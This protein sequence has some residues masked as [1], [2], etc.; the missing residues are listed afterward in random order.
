MFEVTPHKAIIKE[1]HKIVSN[2]IAIFNDGDYDVMYYGTNG[3][4]NRILGIIM[5]DDD[6][7]RFL[8]YIHVLLTDYQLNKYLNGEI[9][10]RSILEENQSF[11]LVD[12]KYNGVELA[13]NLVAFDE[14]PNDFL[15]LPN[16]YCPKFV[17]N[18]TFDYAVSLKGNLADLHLTAPDDLNNVN[19]HFSSFIKSA[20]GFVSDLDLT[21]SVY[22]EAL[23]AG[24]FRINFKLELVHLN[25]LSLFN[26][27]LRNVNQFITSYFKYVLGILPNEAPDALKKDEIDS[28][29][30]LELE[31][32]FYSLHESAGNAP[33]G[34]T[35]QK[36]IDTI[37][38][39]LAN[40][41]DIN[42]GRSFDRLEFISYTSSGAEL[43]TGLIDE[44]YYELATSKLFPIESKKEEDIIEVDE[45]PNEYSIQVYALNKETGNGSAYLN[46]NNGI[47]RISLHVRGKL[48][49][50]NTIFTHNMDE[51]EPTL[52]T[53]KAIAKRINGHVKE[54]TYTFDS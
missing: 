44:K 26:A 12:K 38:Y 2:Y 30:F 11:F 50:Q 14:I 1:L 32:L 45:F 53:I 40:L 39:S 25:P 21:R 27:P 48:N 51:K 4:G 22:V 29:D 37:N 18:S 10:F 16:S 41:K 47:R 52:M 49:Y 15:P 8:R 9:S 24:S 42:F 34:G 3:Y 5:F 28:K 20:T 46:I 17:I 43:P 33:S 23:A 54:I 36:L 6:D 7:N 31:K 13:V 19:S 35:E